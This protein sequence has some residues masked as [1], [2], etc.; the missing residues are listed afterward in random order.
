M[1]CSLSIIAAS[2]DTTSLQFWLY[3]LRPVDPASQPRDKSSGCRI[4][5]S[6]A[7]SPKKY[8]TGPNGKDVP[9]CVGGV[10]MCIVPQPPPKAMNH[11][12]FQASCGA[13]AVHGLAGSAST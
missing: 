10:C 11:L 3:V 7:E 5:P 2:A 6:A 4:S 8:S 12:R 13:V 1:M 9:A